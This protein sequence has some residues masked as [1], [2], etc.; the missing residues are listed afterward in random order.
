MTG[1]HSKFDDAEKDGEGFRGRAGR[2]RGFIFTF[3]LVG[4]WSYV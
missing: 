4:T 2:E 3:G 1:T